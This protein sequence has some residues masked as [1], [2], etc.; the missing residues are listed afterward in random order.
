[1]IQPRFSRAVGK[2][3][4]SGS[5][6]Q[7]AGNLAFVTL[8]VA[9]WAHFSTWYQK[10]LIGL[11]RPLWGII[12]GITS[13]GSMM[14]AIQFASGI[15][16]DLRFAPLA[17]AGLFGGAIAAA[18][19]AIPAIVFRGTVG[20]A[21]AFDGVVAILV[22]SA[23]G[24]V[25]HFAFRR[26]TADIYKLAAV[27][28][29]LGLGLSIMLVTL[30]SLTKSGAASAFGVPLVLMNCVATI[31]CG[32]IMLKTARLKL[33]RQVLETAFSQSPDYLYV[34][35]RDSRFIAVNNNMARLF[36]FSSPA[37]MF[38]LSDFSLRTAPDAE[39]LYHR[40]QEIIRTG[41][42]LVDFLERMGDRH[43][44]AS[45]VP[46]RDS[47][48]Q[49]I[50]L[51]GVTRDITE[52]VDLE[53]ELREK[54]NLLT[55]AMNGM[56]EGF[57]MFDKKGFLI[58]CNEQYRDAFPLSRDARVIGAHI[59]KILQRIIEAGERIGLPEETP[60]KWIEAAAATLH[61]NKDEEI[62]LKNGDW[63]ALK[64]RLAHDGTAMVVVSD[65]TVTK[66]AEAALQLSAQ[67]LRSL[68]DTDGLTSLANRR[69]F[70]A[71]FAHEAEKCRETD[72]PLS[73]LMIDVDRFKLYNDTYGHLAGDECLRAVGN[74][75]G[76]SVKRSTDIVARY[77][78]EEFVVLL[79]N[80]DETG[81]MAV[82]EEFRRLLSQ[83]NIPH[84]T[85]E[86]GRVTASIGISSTGGD[87]LLS[88][89]RRLL[90]AADA[91]LYAAKEQGRNQ[92]KV[93]SP[94]DQISA[95]RAG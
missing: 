48:G 19:A 3:M 32:L 93:Q 87:V 16:I 22:I 18:I 77:G 85:S 4:T 65:I 8:A 26:K 39:D 55:L 58:F 53:R 69:A 41:K 21:G 11:G 46:L 73:V 86:F 12:A 74:C 57:A 64:T 24:A 17:L 25:V 36:H 37:E 34:K 71:A 20:G 91:A 49:I 79:P 43:L 82:A 90:A 56:S 1:M 6:E 28:T 31:V 13:V 59:T 75:L 5:W 88:D 62:Q 80:T 47:E 23:I 68:A 92:I 27:T 54:R 30:P 35:D 76:K 66:Q 2:K 44:L 83:K 72:I 40:E 33:E 38:G 15:Y 61:M 70:D 14:L 29:G 67:Q 95:A 60:E 10:S 89:T 52:R 9:M 81:A 42:P 51:A 63:R 94:T 50:G 45:K 7:F 84:A 78:G